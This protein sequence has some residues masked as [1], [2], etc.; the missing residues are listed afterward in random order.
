MIQLH[1]DAPKQVGPSLGIAHLHPLLGHV[2]GLDAAYRTQ[3][4][5]HLKR[6]TLMLAG[7]EPGALAVERRQESAGTEVAVLNPEVVRLHGLQHL[8]QQRALV[9]MAAFT[10]KQIAPP[11]TRRL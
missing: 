3:R 1:P 4:T 2:P 10:G 7:D 5:H 6:E 9:S 11:A 8:P